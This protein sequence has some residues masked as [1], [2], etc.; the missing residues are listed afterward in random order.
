MHSNTTANSIKPAFKR[1]INNVIFERCLF[2]FMAILE[3]EMRL[4]RWKNTFSVCPVNKWEKE[5]SVLGLCLK[6]L[7]YNGEY[8][9]VCGCVC[10]WTLLE[11][12]S[13]TGAP[14]FLIM[15]I[16]LLIPVT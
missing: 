3:V 7:N 4:K 11:D 16:I 6:F 5:H 1:V 12:K 8:D 14:F 15:N 10:K 13:L 9:I 2:N